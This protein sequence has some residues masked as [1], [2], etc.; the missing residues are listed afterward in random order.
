M[1]NIGQLDN[2]NPELNIFLGE[3]SLWGKGIAKEALNL[4][5]LWLQNKGYQA[6]HTT[7]LENNKRALRLFNSAGFHR[8]GKARV[9]EV[10]VERSIVP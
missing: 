2:W 7:I 9:D 6:V 4:A 1:V 8:A 10:R 3:I 5:I